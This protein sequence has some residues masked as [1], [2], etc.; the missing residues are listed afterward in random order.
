M[1][2][3]VLFDAVGTLVNMA[4]PVPEYEDVMSLAEEAGVSLSLSGFYLSDASFSDTIPKGLFTEHWE[5]I[6]LIEDELE[7]KARDAR[8]Y[9]DTKESLDLIR[10]MGLKVGVCANATQEQTKKLRSL[11]PEI[12]CMV[13]SSEFGIMKPDHRPLAE[14]CK[15]LGVSPGEVLMIGG[16][17]TED[18][19]PS[20]AMGMYATHLVRSERGEND[21]AYCVSRMEK[22]I[23]E[24]VK[25]RADKLE[26]WECVPAHPN[27][28]EAKA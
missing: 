3:A 14:A 1:I 24:R 9:A 5:T 10:K 8:L 20:L 22:G 6:S 4:S 13:L 2:K 21:L 11:L 27:E 17:Y 19:L 25:R 23:P 12:D 7:K 15:L 26:A 28:W 18:Y 16:S